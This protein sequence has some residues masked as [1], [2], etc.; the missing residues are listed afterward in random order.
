[1]DDKKLATIVQ[2]MKALGFEWRAFCKIRGG[3]KYKVRFRE[4][5]NRPDRIAQ[6]ARSFSLLEATEEAARKTMAFIAQVGEGWHIRP[7]K[8]GSAEP[9]E[10]GTR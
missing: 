8:S 10:K 7:I 1:M 4:H 6:A 3:A 2:Q 5:A 9:D